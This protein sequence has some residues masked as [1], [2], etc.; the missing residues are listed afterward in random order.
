MTPA[1][2]IDL[3]GTLVDTAPDLLD[4]LNVILAR[5]GRPAVDL[6]SLRNM[7]GLARA[8][9]WPWPSN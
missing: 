8:L 9:C 3:D 4:A 2:V 6:S 1:F 5:K 7:V